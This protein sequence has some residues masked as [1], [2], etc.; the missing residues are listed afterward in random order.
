[1]KIKSILWMLALFVSLSIGFTSCDP[2]PKKQDAQIEK[3]AIL[4]AFDEVMPSDGTL[5]VENVISTDREYMYLHYKEDYRWY[6]TTVVFADYLDGEAQDGSIKSVTST[7][8]VMYP[9][10][11][12]TSGDAVV[13]FITH[14]L[15]TIRIEAKEGIFVGDYALNSNPI[16]VT[17]TEAYE[18]MMSAN[19]VKPHSRYCVL[20]QPVGPKVANPQYIFG[21]NRAQI[22]V[23]AVNAN[24]VDKN[25]SFGKPLGEWP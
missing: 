9:D 18:K 25:P 3:K 6:E 19:Y 5:T 22:Y 24:V 16:N 12:G 11:G 17:F 2:K 1:M 13:V 20:R 15:N 10:E 21:N 23:D 4:E 14:D 7:F 8:Q